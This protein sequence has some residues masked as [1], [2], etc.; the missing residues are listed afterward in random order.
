MSF[1][2][3]GVY[4]SSTTNVHA[5]GGDNPAHCPAHLGKDDASGNRTCVPTVLPGHTLPASVA[6]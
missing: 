6:R 1:S 5:F 3:T 2:V 4:G